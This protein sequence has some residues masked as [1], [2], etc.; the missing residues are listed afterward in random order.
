M[1]VELECIFC[2]VNISHSNPPSRA[3]TKLKGGIKKAFFKGSNSSC[4]QHIRQH[5]DI[6]QQRCKDLS[7]LESE[8]AV[9]RHIFAARKSASL[10]PSQSPSISELFGKGQGPRD[11]SRELVLERVATFIVTS[12]QVCFMIWYFT[13]QVLIISSR[14]QLQTIPRSETAWPA[15]ARK[16]QIKIFL[17]PTM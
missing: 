13:V 8:H 14:L 3:E 5:Y 9:P 12:N 1:Q 6:Y 4:R 16:Q 7:I 17:Q 10:T 2:P 11:F 15:C